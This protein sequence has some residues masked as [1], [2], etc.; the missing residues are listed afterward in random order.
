MYAKGMVVVEV[1]E[2]KTNSKS[3]VFVFTP[4]F[5]VEEA[6]KPASGK[7]KDSRTGCLEETNKPEYNEP[8]WRAE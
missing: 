6:N 2:R 5:I 7:A 8:V 1:Q 3:D 4:L